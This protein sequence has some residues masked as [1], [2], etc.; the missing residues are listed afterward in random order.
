MEVWTGS[1]RGLS[2]RCA[3]IP[4]RDTHT[5]NVGLQNSMGCLWPGGDE[6]QAGSQTSL[7][8]CR[9]QCGLEKPLVEGAGREVA[10]GQVLGWAGWFSLHTYHNRAALLLLFPALKPQ[11]TCPEPFQPL[12]VPRDPWAQGPKASPDLATAPGPQLSCLEAWNWSKALMGNA[13]RKLRFFFPLGW[14]D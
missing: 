1:W 9:G 12:S 3:G 7:K 10:W 4:G 5:S 14:A 11:Q 13:S 2:F 6:A 8:V